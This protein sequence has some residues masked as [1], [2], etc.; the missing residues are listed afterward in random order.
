[1]EE[2]IRCEHC[3][4]LMHESDTQTVTL[5]NGDTITLCDG[6]LEY[7]YTTCDRCG[8]IVPTDDSHWVSGQDWCPSC[9]EDEAYYCDRCGDYFMR[10]YMNELDGEWYCDSCYAE[11]YDD[12][13]VQG[14]HHTRANHFFTL[15]D[16]NPQNQFFGIELEIDKNNSDDR[17]DCAKDIKQINPE[18]YTCKHDGSLDYGFEIVSQPATYA[19][20]TQ[21]DLWDKV[22]S[23]AVHYG[24]KSHDRNTCG[25][26]IH[27]SRNYFT[28][29]REAL[30]KLWEIFLRNK[31]WLERFSRRK[32]EHLDRWA[33]FKDSSELEYMNKN[34]NEYY[35][36]R[37]QAINNENQYTIEFRLFR[38]TLKYNTFV[39][40]LQLVKYLCE[41]V[42]NQSM[43]DCRRLNLSQVDF[44][45]Y[46]ELV[47]YIGERNLPTLEL[48]DIPEYGNG[49]EEVEEYVKHDEELT[50]TVIRQILN[51]NYGIFRTDITDNFEP[52]Y[53]MDENDLPF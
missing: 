34:K 1:M 37:Y 12:Y 20:H 19:Y 49:T 45:E 9:W 25:L 8:D 16:E 5:W 10:D 31:P 24:F 6:C 18:F 13:G 7:N 3:G 47:A 50:C 2:L 21:A 15:G 46:P 43:H 32:W 22:C 41:Y 30:V 27:V 53:V 29:D 51:T 44:T 40:T 38:G 23:T 36:G 48:E 14:Y 33:K 28:N 11:V 39:A 52:L 35:R 42:N 4:D 26:H 17:H